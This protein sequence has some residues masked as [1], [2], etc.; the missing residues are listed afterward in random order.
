MN[1]LLRY[2]RIL[3]WIVVCT[4]VLGSFIVGSWYESKRIPTRGELQ[5]IS[6]ISQNYSPAYNRAIKKSRMSAVRVLSFSEDNTA[7]STTSGTYFENNGRYY[8]ITTQ[9]GILGP[10][11]F[12][13]IEFQDKTYAC[14]E[15]IKIDPLNDYA[16]IEIETSMENRIP[17]Q[18]P[19][20]LPNNYQW[21][22]SYAILSNIVY[23][24]YANALGPLTLRGDVI[25]YTDYNY[26]YV[27][28][29]AYGGASG[30]GV[31]SE[32]GKYM[33]YVTALDVGITEFGIEVL[34][35]V[36][37]VTPAHK[38]DWDAISN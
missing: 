4:A 2:L 7:T 16:I 18:I 24:G 25:G 8:I 22:S 37:L 34:E 3:L 38:I 30:S 21:K 29:Y 13:N 14:K 31:F 19:A 6:N 33:G 12:V 11:E 28:S 26:L 23:T 15:Y 17:I 27:F 36:V 5:D 9:H 20:D 10:C 1:S 32:K 35:N